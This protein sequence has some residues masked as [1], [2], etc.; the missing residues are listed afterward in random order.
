MTIDALL[1]DL[2]GTLLDTNRLHARAFV[3][4]FERHGF[5]V[6][7]ERVGR[8]IGKG[9]ELLVPALIGRQ[10]D[11]ERGEEIRAAKEEIFASLLDDEPVP[12]IAGVHELF[13]AAR[14]RGLATAVATASKRAQLEMMLERAGLDLFD[15]ADEVVTDDDVDRPKPRPDVVAAAAEKLGLDPGRCAMVGDTPYDAEAA[16]GAGAAGLGVETG[17]WSPGELRA[18]GMRAVYRDVGALAADLD[19]ALALAAEPPGAG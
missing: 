18:A 7:I 9:G 15:L 13:A 17:G 10:A 8:E 2:D 12:V 6:S 4:A 5:D 3:G 1:L 19:A 11:E 14:E 16:R